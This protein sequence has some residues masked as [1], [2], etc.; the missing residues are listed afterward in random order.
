[1]LQGFGFGDIVD[2][3][4]AIYLKSGTET[5][6]INPEKMP[7]MFTE[8]PQTRLTNHSKYYDFNVVFSDLVAE[9]GANE[10]DVESD[11]LQYVEDLV[12][13]LRQNQNDWNYSLELSSNAT[14]FHERGDNGYSGQQVNISIEFPFHYDNCI[15]PVESALYFFGEAETT[16]PYTVFSFDGRFTTTYFITVFLGQYQ[17]GTSGPPVNSTT[18][19]TVPTDTPGYPDPNIMP[20]FAAP[21]NI[22]IPGFVVGRVYL[23]AGENVTVTHEEITQ[24]HTIIPCDL[25]MNGMVFNTLNSSKTDTSFEVANTGNGGWLHY[26]IAIDGAL[27]NVRSISDV[28]I[29]GGGDDWEF[30]PFEDADYMAICFDVLYPGK[31]PT[32][33]KL[34]NKVTITTDDSSL[35]NIILIKY[36]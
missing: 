15:I 9:S 17:T 30:T 2:F 34:S 24:D 13:Y 31:L 32:I 11:C 23:S 33:T 8:S 16:A 4:D 14:P 20:W 22:P 18:G 25:G 29:N 10:T 26:V 5:G 27:P 28:A 36:P 3:E 21:L 6:K 7:F 1:M 12:S 19:F 35:Y